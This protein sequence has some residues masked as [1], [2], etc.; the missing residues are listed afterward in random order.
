MGGN[1]EY[2]SLKHSDYSKKPTNSHDALCE[3]HEELVSA[4]VFFVVLS[5]ENTAL[6]NLGM[7]PISTATLPLTS[8][9]T[10]MF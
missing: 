8:Y 2:S 10:Y 7:R 4:R 3:G 5:S 9:G 1:D 6:K